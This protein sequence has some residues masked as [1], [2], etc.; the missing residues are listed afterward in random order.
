MQKQG[1]SPLVLKQE[2][3]VV[4]PLVINHLQVQDSISRIYGGVV[5]LLLILYFYYYS[6]FDWIAV[7]I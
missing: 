6:T 5:G 1:G 3:G 2:R 4:L 7:F